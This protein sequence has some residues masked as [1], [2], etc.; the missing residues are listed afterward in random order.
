MDT[1]MPIH[2]QTKDG[3]IS[4]LPGDDLYPENPD[5]HEASYDFQKFSD[6]SFEE[7]R[8]ISKNLCRTEHNGLYEL[9]LI[10]N[11]TP[12]DGHFQLVSDPIA[13]L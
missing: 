5:Y 10:A 12:R 11:V 6:K 8:E 3:L 1:M 2:F 4:T 13:K 9:R 7:M